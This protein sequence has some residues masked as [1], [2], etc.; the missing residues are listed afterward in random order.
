MWEF[1]QA[2]Y[3]WRLHRFR[4]GGGGGGGRVYVSIGGRWIRIWSMFETAEDAAAVMG[5][6]AIG[7]GCGHQPR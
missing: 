2:W 6:G 4:T 1:V 3:C 7:P 5:G